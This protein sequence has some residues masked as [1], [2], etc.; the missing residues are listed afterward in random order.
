[1]R[2]AQLD[3]SVRREAQSQRYVPRAR[4]VPA[5]GWRL[6]GSYCPASCATNGVPCPSG[7]FCAG[8]SAP[9]VAAACTASSF[10]LPSSTTSTGFGAA[11][12]GDLDNDC[13]LD[14]VV[15]LRLGGVLAYKGISASSFAS[16]VTLDT[17]VCSG[18]CFSGIVIADLDNDGLPDVMTAAWSQKWFRNLG[19]FAFAS[20]AALSTGLP[21]CNASVYL[22]D[23]NNDGKLDAF[24]QSGATVG[25]AVRQSGSAFGPFSGILQLPSAADYSGIAVGDIDSDGNVDLVVY[26]ELF[27]GTAVLA[28]VCFRW[29]I[30]QLCPQTGRIMCISRTSTATA[31]WTLLPM[32][33]G[34][35]IGSSI[36]AQAASSA[37]FKFFLQ[38]TDS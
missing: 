20:G 10:A 27:T 4:T 29:Q 38:T 22:G 24:L 3:T 9:A 32:W 2:S 26:D 33:A 35:C 23:F 6:Q 13:V 17:P 34:L 15:V 19:A 30:L 21:F 18:N 37:H 31:G 28:Q 11:A 5:C 36:T 12:I 14:I 16:P 8:G 7:S 25:T 1:M